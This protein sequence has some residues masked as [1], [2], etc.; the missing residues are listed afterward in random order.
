MDQ[1]YR[2]LAR[3]RSLAS[4]RAVGGSAPATLGAMPD[5]GPL[6]LIIVL[7]I[8]LVVF[9]PKRLPGPGASARRGHARVQGLDHRQGRRRRRRARRR[10]PRGGA[11]RVPRSEAG[12]DGRARRD[13]R[14]GEARPQDQPARGPTE[15]AAVPAVRRVRPIGHEDRLSLVEHLDE[16]RT[17]LIICSLRLR[18]GLRG[19][20]LAE[21]LAAAR[22]QQAA[23]AGAEPQ[24]GRQHHEQG[25][26]A[27]GA[28]H[29]RAP[30]RRRRAAHASPVLQGQRDI[31]R[32]LSRKQQA[33]GR[34]A[35][36]ARAARTSCCA[37]ALAAAAGRRPGGAAQPGAPA[38]HARGHR[39]VH[40]DVHRRG[41]RRA[42]ARRCRS[43]STR[44]TRSSC[45]RSARRSARSRC[46]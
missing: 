29:L 39:A 12:A 30:G 43:S 41:L 37:K 13:G 2:L 40:D 8:V 9:G 19:L 38:G 34:R 15:R 26:P 18:R 23:R 10:R 7:V 32:V 31:N 46:R 5:I 17:R 28:G 3:K 25:R 4:R 20:L 44:P 21:R 14:R 27:A 11:R 35:G 1:R 36:A 24:P 42:A 22:D 16:L 45:R 33:L 6:E